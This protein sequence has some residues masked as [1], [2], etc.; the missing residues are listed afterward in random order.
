MVVGGP[1]I[2]NRPGLGGDFLIAMQSARYIPEDLMSRNSGSR[3]VG[4]PATPPPSSDHPTGTESLSFFWG[5][6]AL[7]ALAR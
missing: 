1:I 3:F 7:L 6:L 4:D 5:S 2:K